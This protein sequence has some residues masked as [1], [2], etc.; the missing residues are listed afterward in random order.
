MKHLILILLLVLISCAPTKETIG[1]TYKE[2][3]QQDAETKGGTKMKLSSNAFNEGEMIPSKYTCQGEDINPQLTIED[4]P[5]NT[6]SLALIV[7]DPD[8]PMGT[9]VHWLV[10][11]IPIT[12][13]IKENSVPGTQV[14]NDFGKEDYGGPCPPSGT[15]R[16]FFK[17]FALDVE[18][19]E[20]NNKED[21]YKQ[22]EQH[23]IAKAELIGKYTKE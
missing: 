21:F 18:K 19:L 13:E 10:K 23:A 9:W 22:T 2:N 8:A 12:N 15:H 11:D 14:A 20:A 17:V 5:E 7:D 4:I 3:A 1:Q 6:K 16:Y